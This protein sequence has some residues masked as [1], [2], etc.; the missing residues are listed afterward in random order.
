VLE[1]L[2]GPAFNHIANT[3]V[4]AFVRRVD[5]LHLRAQ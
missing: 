1:R 2:A 5:E 4:D 3:F